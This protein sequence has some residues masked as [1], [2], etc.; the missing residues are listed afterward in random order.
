MA[1]IYCPKC[2]EPVE[3]D[4]LH[5]VAEDHATTFA[6]VRDQ[7][8]TDGCPAIDSTCNP[9]THKTRAAVSAMLADLYGDDVDG[10]AADM[11]DLAAM[12]WLD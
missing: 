5:D 12:G 3:L 11:D 1:D 2:G 6:K 8:F 9:R 10:I 4:Y 7:F